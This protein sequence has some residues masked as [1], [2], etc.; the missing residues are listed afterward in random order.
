MKSTDLFADALWQYHHTGRAVLWTER[1]DG[2]LAREDISWYFTTPREFPAHE[3]AALKF[4]RGRILDIGCGAGR[5]SLYFQKRGFRVTAIDASPSIVELARL[6]GVRDVRLGNAC[7]ARALPFRDGEF[8]TVVL[9]GNNLGIGGTLRRFRRMLREIHR[10]T[11]PQGR[12]LATTRQ[13]QAEERTGA[14]YPRADS[15]SGSSVKEVRLRLFTARPEVKK[16]RPRV[17][18]TPS[19]SS[20]RCPDAPWITLLLLSPIDLMSIAAREKWE[21]TH[22]IPLLT[23]QKGYAVVLEK[24][25]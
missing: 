22:L 7:G 6:R 20:S 9:F 17:T 16:E 24:R 21:M 25:P 10:V 2:R 18:K 23:F 5:H 3:K 4:A 13:P 11:S 8:D 12:I 15:P 19:L 14:G 1:D